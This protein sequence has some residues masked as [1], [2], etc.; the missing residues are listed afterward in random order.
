VVVQLQDKVSSLELR[1]EELT[2]HIAES[3]TAA[4]RNKVHAVELES[5]LQDKVAALEL[6]VEELTQQIASSDSV[7]K[8]TMESTVSAYETKIEEVEASRQELRDHVA[9][10]T[11]EL[12]A[13]RQVAEDI[14]KTQEGDTQ[15]SVDLDDGFTSQLLKASVQEY[16]NAATDVHLAIRRLQSL[17]LSQYSQANNSS[18]DESLTADVLDVPET[19]LLKK[20]IESKVSDLMNYYYPSILS[21]TGLHIL[22]GGLCNRY[23]KR[24][25][26]QLFVKQ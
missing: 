21:I 8:T 26:S 4:N 12:E 9:V 15:V 6:R 19:T 10:L 22:S 23:G 1:V 7:T 5:Q 18:L 16:N 25:P 2:Q 3:E 14:H 11:A 17:K 13:T 24:N 20:L